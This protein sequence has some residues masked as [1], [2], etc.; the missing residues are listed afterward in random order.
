MHYLIEK[1]KEICQVAA[2][3]QLLLTNVVGKQ[4]ESSHRAP[5]QICSEK[6]VHEDSLVLHFELCD[7][8][9]TASTKYVSSKVLKK[10]GTYAALCGL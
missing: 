10:K 3:P 8:T 6:T 1:L 9:E 7:G 5:R 2:S 4:I